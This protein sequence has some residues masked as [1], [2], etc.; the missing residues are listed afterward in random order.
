MSVLWYSFRLFSLRLRLEHGNGCQKGEKRKKL[1]PWFS[2]LSF[3]KR[4]LWISISELD[5][6]RKSSLLNSSP[7][8]SSEET[9]FFQ[10]RVCVN[11]NSFAKLKRSFLFLSSVGPDHSVLHPRVH[12]VSTFSSFCRS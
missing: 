4:R 5:F 1:V 8:I 3:R 12:L 11:G 7:A 9:Y 10:F 6:L 2:I